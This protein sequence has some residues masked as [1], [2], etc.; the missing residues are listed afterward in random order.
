MPK[1][2]SVLKKRKT[3]AVL[4]KPP[5]GVAI[6][7]VDEAV[8]V[9]DLRS[10]IRS[11]RQ[12]V[13]TVANAAQALVYWRLGSRLLK[14]NLQDQRATYGKRIVATVSQQL[15]D[16]FGDGFSYSSLTRVVRFAEIQPDEAI[17]ATLSQQL[18]WWHVRALLPIKDPLARDFHAEKAPDR[19]EEGMN[20]A[21]SNLP[22]VTL[23]VTL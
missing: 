16:E 21:G 13:A 6:A 12:R 2:T 10:L 4:R 23:R 17:V 9:G 5:S 22:V 18:G 3:G 14:E 7:T 15:R 8:L 1:N 20:T 19:V 11:A